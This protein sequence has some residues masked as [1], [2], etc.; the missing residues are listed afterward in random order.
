M[1][2]YAEVDIINVVIKFTIQVAAVQKKQNWLL[3]V[4]DSLTSKFIFFLLRKKKKE[5]TTS[6]ALFV[7]I[8][9]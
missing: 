3:K 4:N 5:N 2:R 7:Q 6:A 9:Q 1:I 8:G